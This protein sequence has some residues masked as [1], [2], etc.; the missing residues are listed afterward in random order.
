MTHES[1][2]EYTFHDILTGQELRLS[3]F[4]GKPL[5]IVNTASYCG[6][7]PQLDELEELWQKYHSKGL[8]I[9]GVPCNDFGAQEPKSEKDIVDFCT[10]NFDVTFPMCQKTHVKGNQAHPFYQWAKKQVGWFGSPKWN[11]HKYLLDKEGRLSNWFFPFTKPSS[12]KITRSI[13][14]ILEEV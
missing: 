1:A 8:T 14:Q 6:F 3:A 13:E 7:T 11:F 12:K 4:K 5:L 2:Y 10:R 9:I